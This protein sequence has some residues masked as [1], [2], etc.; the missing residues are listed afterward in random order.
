MLRSELCRPST[1]SPN[2]LITHAHTA[3]VGCRRWTFR[4]RS[5]ISTQ[6]Q[7][8]NPGNQGI[9]SIWF[10]VRCEH[11]DEFDCHLTVM[12]DAYAVQGCPHSSIL[13]FKLTSRVHASFT[14]AVHE[15]ITWCCC[16]GEATI[17]KSGLLYDPAQQTSTKQ[18]TVSQT[19]MSSSTYSIWVEPQGKLRHISTT[20]QFIK[21]QLTEMAQTL[22]SSDT[23]W[24]ISE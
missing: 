18:L 7:A 10:S 1:T 3:R 15:G 24:L 4:C 23:L 20:G 5:S 2:L 9:L 12:K 8:S 21:L 14:E 22:M 16:A 6:R 19:Q 17:S 13:Q 11:V